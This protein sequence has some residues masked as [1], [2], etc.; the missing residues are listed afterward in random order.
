MCEAM[1][2]PSSGFAAGELILKL[3]TRGPPR[4]QIASDLHLEFLSSLPQAD[5]DAKLSAMIVPSAPVLALLGDIGIP[6][7]PIYRRFLLQQA[8]RF[9]AVL[10]IAGN[11]EFYDVKAPGTIPMKPADMSW[12]EFYA[13]QG[14]SKNTVQDMSAAITAICDEHP[15]LHYVEG[16]CV[17][18]GE[19]PQAAALLCTTLWS[20]IPE[21]AM[22]DVHQ[23]LN[24]YAMIYKTVDEADNPEDFGSGRP[25]LDQRGSHICKLTPVHTSRWHAEAVEWL[26]AEISRLEAAGGD[27]IGILSHHAPVMHGTS[28]PE[29]EGGS[30]NHAFASDLEH[31]CKRP[32]VKL[33]AYGHTHFNNDQ[34]VHGCRVLSNQLGYGH[35]PTAYQ[36]D[37]VFELS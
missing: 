26:Q 36:S 21:D 5:Q 13:T 29:H 37:F 31:L 24:D 17:R 11:H 23:S 19:Q 16:T 6:T 12:G 1:A 27:R 18:F 14:S 2:A 15:C 4:V 7:H 32:A 25:A 9:E 8:E 30:V 28:A 20:H 35:E 10:V 34:V 33:W 3:S 22:A